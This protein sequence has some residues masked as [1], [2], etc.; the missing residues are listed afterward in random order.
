VVKNTSGTIEVFN[1]VTDE[2]VS[3]GSASD[4]S[5]NGLNAPAILW[6]GFSFLIGVPMACAGIRGWRFT[7]GVGI[8]CALAVLAWAAFINTMSAAGI[9]DMLL[10]LIVFA[11][12]FVGSMLGWFEFARLAGIILI[13]FVGGLA[14]G[15]RIAI[16]KEDLLISK[17][18]LFSLDWVIVL[19]FT[20]SAGATAIWKQRLALVIFFSP[21][22]SRT[23]FVGLGVDLIIQKQKGM[24]RGLIYLFDRN[25]A[26]LADLYTS[27]YKPQL[28]TRIVI[29][30]TLGLT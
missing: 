23:F 4:G 3:Q 14:F 19:V 27:G 15:V 20:V 25:S 12:F 30:V 24:G 8:G 17:T 5:G 11:F 28:S 21:Q 16:I 22:V 10:L 1:T 7:V 18:S 13:A 2:D 6:I 9:P 26:H 29:Y